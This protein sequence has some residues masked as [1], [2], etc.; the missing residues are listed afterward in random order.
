MVVYER[1]GGFRGTRRNDEEKS[2]RV[3]HRYEHV[4]HSSANRMRVSVSIYPQSRFGAIQRF[5]LTK[6]YYYYIQT[7]KHYLKF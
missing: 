3:G 7:Y 6:N 2:E 4:G 1:E 5:V